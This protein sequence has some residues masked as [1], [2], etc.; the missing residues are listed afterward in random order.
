MSIALDFTGKVVAITG[1][2]KGVGRG[3]VTRFLEAGAT[4]EYCARTAPDEPIGSASF[5]AVDV[6]DAE[7]VASWI[8]GIAERHGRLDVLVNNVGGSP[9]SAFKDGSPRYQKAIMEINFFSASYACHAAYPHLEKTGGNVVNI[10][11][12]SARRPSPGTAVYGAAKAALENLTR[13]LGAEWAPRIRVNA[14]SSG[15]VG[16]ESADGHYGT[17]EQLAGVAATIPRGRLANPLELG[18]TCVMLASDL[19]SHTTGAILNVDGGGEWPAFLVHTPNADA[20]PA[21]RAEDA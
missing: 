3:I 21:E 8:D 19:S 15:L 13:T 6:R 12:I 7:Q 4:V 1:G 10:T 2:S 5:T 9:F 16:T 11:S 14:I 20:F 18:A 17:P